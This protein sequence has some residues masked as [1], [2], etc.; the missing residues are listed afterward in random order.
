MCLPLNGWKEV[1]GGGFVI[2][3]RPK[4][5]TGGKDRPANLTSGAFLY[6]NV[7]NFRNFH[8]IGKMYSFIPYRT[9]VIHTLHSLCIKLFFGHFGLTGRSSVFIFGEGRHGIARALQLD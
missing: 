2:F 6:H 1:G 8:Y 4:H 9:C 3:L 5:Y 7:R